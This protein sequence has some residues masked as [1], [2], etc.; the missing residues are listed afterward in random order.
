MI[1]VSFLVAAMAAAQPP[2]SAAPAIYVA[3]LRN[4]RGSVQICMTRNPRHFPDCAKDPS[5]LT[6]TVPASAP[7]AV[8]PN[9]PPGHYAVALFHDENGNHKLDKSLGIPREG[10][11]FS[12]NPKIRLGP[13][14]FAETVT[15]IATGPAR[16]DIRIKY[17]L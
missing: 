14:T 3:G 15:A 12:R 17:L 2:I 10:F 6:R 8:F 7:V 13:P 11:G 1:T 9:V 5:A 4:A 16:I